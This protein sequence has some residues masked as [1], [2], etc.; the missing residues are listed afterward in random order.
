MVGDAE[1]GRG[2][3]QG[4]LQDDC[5]PGRRQSAGGTAPSRPGVAPGIR[6]R[7][8]RP[9]APHTLRAAASSAPTARRHGDR[10][11]RLHDALGSSAVVPREREPLA[12]LRF[13]RAVTYRHTAFALAILVGLVAL[14]GLAGLSFQTSTGDEVG[15]F[16]KGSGG[17]KGGIGG[18]GDGPAAPAW[19][20]AAPTVALAA[21]GEQGNTLAPARTE[22]PL[23]TLTAWV[24]PTVAHDRDCSDFKS[25]RQASRWFGQHHPRRDLSGLD[26]DHDG[27]A[28]EGRPCPCSR[29]RVRRGRDGPGRNAR[30]S[31][32]TP[33]LVADESGSS[34]S[35]ATSPTSTGTTGAMSV[36]TSRGSTPSAAPTPSASVTQSVRSVDRAVSGAGVQTGLSQTT[37]G[38]IGRLRRG[39]S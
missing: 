23:F 10:A 2:A 5:G 26:R 3:G 21:H 17:A 35:T 18:D 24:A 28:C 34:G 4:A 33:G 30:P 37:G 38:L 7:V 36:P 6:R 8:D 16:A 25:Q 9:L 19:T 29:D 15:S 27:R 20:P 13:E 39:G 14:L 12:R 32:Q 22:P 11:K 31:E 1:E